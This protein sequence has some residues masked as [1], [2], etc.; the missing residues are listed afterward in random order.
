M[1]F[2]RLVAR[3]YHR[4]MQLH[5]SVY[6]CIYRSMRAQSGDWRETWRGEPVL[7]RK[8]PRLQRILSATYCANPCRVVFCR[9]FIM[10]NACIWLTPID[11]TYKFGSYRP[12][13]ANSTSILIFHNERSHNCN[14]PTFKFNYCLY[15][16]TIPNS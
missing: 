10:S 3:S 7:S 8:S 2:L 16:V 5:A 1:V 13:F 14:L 12:R 15:T 11:L 6:M 4:F 9:R